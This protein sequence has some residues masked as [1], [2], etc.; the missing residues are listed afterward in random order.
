MAVDCASAMLL[1]DRRAHPGGEAVCLLGLSWRRLL[2]VSATVALS[3]VTASLLWR[4][5]GVGALGTLAALF[6]PYLVRSL[7]AVPVTLRLRRLSPPGKY[8]VIRSLA[9]TR[10]GAGAELLCSVLGEADEKRWS[11]LLDA[12]NEALVPYY[13]RFGFVARGAGV[14][15]PGASTKVRMWRP[16]PR[17]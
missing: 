10:S 7:M 9:S 5:L 4:P 8:V 3:G 15:T 14:V 13:E 11:I 6:T 16:A 12:G 17:P 2:A 1:Y